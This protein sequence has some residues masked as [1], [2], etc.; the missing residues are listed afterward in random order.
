[1]KSQLMIISSLFICLLTGCNADLS[2]S[3][4]YEWIQQEENGL[5]VQKEDNGYIIDLQYL[6][7]DWI[8]YQQKTTGNGKKME[9]EEP[10]EMHYFKMTLK[11]KDEQEDLIQ[12][13]SPSEAAIAEKIDFL[14]FGFKNHLKMLAVGE[15]HPCMLFHYER[16]FGLKSQKNLMLSFPYNGEQEVVIQLSPSRITDEQLTFKFDLTAIPTLSKY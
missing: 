15:E 14:S 6:P 3:E 10:Q 9:V 4:Y 2:P 8:K 1:M 5:R 16:S 7:D 11:R 13:D 12:F